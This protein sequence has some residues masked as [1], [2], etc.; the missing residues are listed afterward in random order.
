M[1]RAEVIAAFELQVSKENVL[2]PFGSGDNF[3][4]T[5]LLEL[6]CHQSLE[7]VGLLRHFTMLS[8]EFSRLLF[9]VFD[10]SEIKN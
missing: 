5:T 7:L 1:F 3:S 2:P 10:G 8:V 4:S 9:T 6:L